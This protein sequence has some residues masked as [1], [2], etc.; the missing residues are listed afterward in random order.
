MLIVDVAV[1]AVDLAAHRGGL[2]MGRVAELAPVDFV[3][4][5]S[6]GDFMRGMHERV[7]EEAVVQ[8]PQPRRVG[9]RRVVVVGRVDREVP[10]EVL[11]DGIRAA[12]VFALER[13][14]REVR[15]ELQRRAGNVV[16][17][18]VAEAELQEG[19]AVVRVVLGREV[20]QELLGEPLQRVVSPDR[21]SVV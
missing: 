12:Q 2:P 4:V 20:R 3:V 11:E 5:A 8:R 9:E 13:F 18:P 17:A 15:P 21:K 6:L 19:D 1:P 7:V 10:G 16:F 14:G